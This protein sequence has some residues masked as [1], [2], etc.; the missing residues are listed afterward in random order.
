MQLPANA[1]NSA[2]AAKY[3][4]SA[5]ALI[6]EDL[7]KVTQLIDEQLSDSDIYITRLVEF[8]GKY[9]GKMIRPALVL[10][11]AE[12][13]GEITQEHIRVAAIFE[14]I[15]NA[16]LL[17]DDV[18]DEG[19]R[20]RG[21]DTVN[22]IWGNES[23]VL[24]GDFLL[25]R[26]LKMCSELDPRFI[27]IISVAVSHTCEG[28]LKQIGQ[29][30]NVELTEDEYIDIISNKSASLFSSCCCIG[31]LL[32]GADQIQANSLAQFG[33]N[34]GIAFQITDDLIDIIGDETKAGKSLGSDA[35]KQKLTLAFIH[36]LKHA[37]EKNKE[38]LMNKLTADEK[39][40]SHL[41]EMLKSSQ[42]L[43]YAKQRARD[44]AD[45]AIGSLACLKP[46]DA[47][48][49]LIETAEFAISRAF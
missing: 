3:D 46:G 39:G 26:V 32:A 28:E 41:L 1:D 13:C 43:T 23:A 5:F 6:A 9:R 49:A 8:F 15:H 19:K 45:K 14:M 12:A 31:G 2:S 44:F 4:I 10:L 34:L 48:D 42:S 33:L 37:D 20:R 22:S 30:Q 47:K 24:L 21:R 29:K 18:I 11:A 38:L 36:F 35:D 7:T 27:K 16:T 25:S 40:K 17:H